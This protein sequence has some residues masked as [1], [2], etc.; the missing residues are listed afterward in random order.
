MHIQIWL[1][2]S[3]LTLYQSRATSMQGE[4]SATT[5]ENKN[6]KEKY[7]EDNKEKK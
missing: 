7:G 3:S 2:S 5:Q 4:N 6:T 1:N